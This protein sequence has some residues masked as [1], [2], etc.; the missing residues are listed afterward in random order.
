MDDIAR[1]ANITKRT[2]YRYV[3]SKE[4]LLFDIHDTFS[5]EQL[6]SDGDEQGDDPV[7]AFTQL[8]RLHVQ[9]VADHTKEIGVFFEERKH[10]TGDRAMLIEQRRNA[11]ESHAVSVIRAGIA[12]GVFVDLNPRVTAQAVLG[13]MTEMYRWYRADG[14]LSASQVAELNADLFLHGSATDRSRVVHMESSK[15][16]PI[17]GQGN[18]G[19]GAKQRVL[20]A[21]TRSFARAGYH[22]S[23]VRDLADLAEV[24]KGAVMYHA[25]YKQDLLEEIHR[26][27]FTS[28]MQELKLIARQPGV[29]PVQ[30]L[31][32]L[33]ASH[34]NFLAAHKDAILVINENMRYLDS[35]AYRRVDKL[36][37]AWLSIFRSVFQEGIDK[38]DFRDL[39]AGFMTRTLVGIFN[40]ATLWYNPQGR[41]RPRDLAE[42]ILHV[43][44]FGLTK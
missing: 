3:T 24:T 30:K 10:L 19:N 22:A 18:A 39:G 23:S 1:A 8:V 26:T 34:I 16:S 15:K 42:I 31:A 11:Y 20:N 38:G 41:L 29:D 17:R 14:P 27:T 2:L 7:A 6:L 36:R 4:E 9:M 37:T 13:G 35:K 12:Q 44:L 5:G 28:S 21:A 43:I 33:I 32:D 40:S 25:G